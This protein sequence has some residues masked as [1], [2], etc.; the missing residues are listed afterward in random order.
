MVCVVFISSIEAYYAQN[1]SYRPKSMDRLF[2]LYLTTVLT[3]RNASWMI[4]WVIMNCERGNRCVLIWGN[5]P[6]HVWWDWECPHSP[7]HQYNSDKL[8]C[9]PIKIWTRVFPN[10]LQTRDSLNSQRR[11]VRHWAQGHHFDTVSVLKGVLFLQR[12]VKCRENAW[13]D[14]RK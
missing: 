10:T 1:V 8:H 2:V 12:L 14:L 3:T 6:S 5:L 4:G 9:L 11:F 13:E 7:Y